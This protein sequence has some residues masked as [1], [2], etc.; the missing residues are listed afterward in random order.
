MIKEIIIQAYIFSK[1]KHKNQKRKYSS[2][3]YF[4]HPKAVARILEDMHQ[5]EFVIA[6]GL[7]HDVVEDTNTTIKELSDKFGSRVANLVSEV[8]NTKEE[9]GD[10]SK[11]DYL[12]CKIKKMS[13]DAL[14]IKLAD[15]LHNVL[16]LEEDLKGKE[17]FH[18]GK[19]YLKQTK[20]ILNSLK[21]SKLS[22]T[23]KALYDRIIGLI[24][25]FEV[26]F[27]EK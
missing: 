21:Y 13:E 26:K 25:Y 12:I 27:Y 18:F 22:S 23:Q 2:H 1:E 4:V 8:T 19:Y 11:E 3:N 5:N 9:R 6:A 7:L 17:H 24:K 16:F 10:L 15:R 20:I 14:T